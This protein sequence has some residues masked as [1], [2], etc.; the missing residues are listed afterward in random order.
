VSS[1]VTFAQAL[2]RGGIVVARVH[3]HDANEMGERY[4]L[5]KIMCKAWKL[6]AQGIYSG[7]T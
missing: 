2:E 6:V 1:L 3:H 4:Y 5:A 7:N